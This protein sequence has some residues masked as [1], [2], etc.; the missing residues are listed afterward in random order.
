MSY[1]KFENVLTRDLLTEEY[2]E[3][4]RSTWAIADDVGCTDMTVARYLRK[5]GIPLRNKGLPP[6]DLTG[7]KFGILTV[8]C[9]SRPGKSGDRSAIWWCDCECGGVK[10]VASH[11]LNRGM[12]TSCGCRSSGGRTHHKYEGGRYISKTRWGGIV[13]G[14]SVRGIPLEVTLAEVEEL[15]V[16]Q[17]FRCALTGLLITLPESGKDIK[18]R[19]S[20]A[21]LDRIDSS[22]GYTLDNVQ[23]VHKCVNYMKG[24]MD[25]GEFVEMCKAVAKNRGGDDI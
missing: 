13:H 22:K 16:K 17:G 20:T 25:E 9:Y 23:W 14:A 5:Y 2:L 15:L 19:T 8:R 1:S 21:S 10:E 3:K 12:T 11:R 4:K 7:K 6:T 24:K 18:R